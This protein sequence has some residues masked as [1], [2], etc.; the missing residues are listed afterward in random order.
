MN[1]SVY[2]LQAGVGGKLFHRM[3][4]YILPISSINDD[5]GW[6]KI[7]EIVMDTKMYIRPHLCLAPCLPH[8]YNVHMHETTLWEIRLRISM[9]LVVTCSIC[10]C[11]KCVLCM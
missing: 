8:Q 2:A 1:I 4:H 6:L 10:T 11:A 9:T 5:L 3:F 7:K